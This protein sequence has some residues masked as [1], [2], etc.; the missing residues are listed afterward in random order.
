MRTP[1]ASSTLENALNLY[2]PAIFAK[3]THD[4]CAQLLLVEIL[5]ANF[6]LV[7]WLRH[8]SITWQYNA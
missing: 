6:L 2:A 8:G 4:P 3:K 5:N 1:Q 7:D